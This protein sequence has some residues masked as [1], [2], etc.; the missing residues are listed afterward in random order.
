M[1]QLPLSRLPLD[2]DRSPSPT[3]TDTSTTD[4]SATDTSTD[5]LDT[6]TREPAEEEVGTPDLVRLYLDEIGKAPLL[7]A[8]TEVTWRSAS[9]PASTPGTCW[10]GWTL[11]TA[12]GP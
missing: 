5:V 8:A 4:N 3:A 10:R 12:A 9:R 11:C 1:T 7:D 6:A 2:T